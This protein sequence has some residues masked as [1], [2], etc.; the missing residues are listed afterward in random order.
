MRWYLFALCALSLPASAARA[1]EPVRAP[2]STPGSP[3]ELD[4]LL[5]Y[6]KFDEAKGTTAADAS[7]N[8]L[9]ATLRGGHWST[10][11]NGAALQ[12]E[13]NGE[14]LDY[15]NSPALNFKAS[16][17]FTFAGWVKSK[18][19]RGAIV[20]QRNSRDAGAA[21]DITLEDGKLGALVRS[22][23]KENGEHAFVTGG[24]INDGDWHHFALT[25][26]S[27]TNIELFIDGAS[28]GKATGADAGGPITTNLR[29]LGSERLWV[30]KKIPNAQFI[31]AI[32][33]FCVFDRAL[34]AK[35]IRQLAGQVRK[36]AKNT[37]SEDNPRKGKPG[38]ID[39]KERTIEFSGVKVTAMLPSDA[40]P[41]ENTV[42]SKYGV[43]LENPRVAVSLT[44]DTFDKDDPYPIDDPDAKFHRKR[45]EQNQKNLGMK[46]EY[47]K[48]VKVS[49][50]NGIE[51]LTMPQTTKEGIKLDNG[52][53][54]RSFYLKRTAVWASV[55]FLGDKVP[56]EIVRKVFDSMKIEFV[57]P[58]REDPTKIVEGTK[59]IPTT[60]EKK[61]TFRTPARA[62][63]HLTSSGV[64]WWYPDDNEVFD[65][66]VIEG[67]FEQSLT[68]D[69][70]LQ[71]LKDSKKVSTNATLLKKA[72]CGK[73]LGILFA[74]GKTD[75]VFSHR[76]AAVIDPGAVVFMRVVQSNNDRFTRDQVKQFLNSLEIDTAA[77]AIEVWEEMLPAQIKEYKIKEAGVSVWLDRAP[78]V[79]AEKKRV[80]AY[81]PDSAN[82]K[83]EESRYYLI[84]E[85]VTTT[86]A[87]EF[88]LRKKEIGD[89][90]FK[91]DGPRDSRRLRMTYSGGRHGI[92]WDGQDRNRQFY[93][94]ILGDKQLRMSAKFAS[95]KDPFFKLT[96]LTDDRAK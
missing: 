51:S 33:E 38:N 47:V 83:P 58:L 79:K 72:D 49:G 93:F 1:D 13:K 57:G 91:E 40:S 88:E 84:V 86:L 44:I 21:I 26:D 30:Q 7:R 24:L 27:G 74:E 12:F 14:Y 65:V 71:F 20:S 81:W 22:D 11:V 69:G 53:A 9:K 6:W 25:R 56:E 39:W 34:S 15:G 42:S 59:G 8:K 66:Q 50:F 77:P 48:T 28:E 19:Q 89:K 90:L 52:T 60:I 17:A 75:D 82:T 23:Y 61:V 29:T 31:G 62:Q 18:S 10:G 64:H 87:K 46:Y 92:I 85:P 94:T 37:E 95:E 54:N 32:D 80:I 78:K 3:A 73:Q 16:T 2:K 45:I 43:V 96:K 70:L 63:K 41:R 5:A 67:Y 68:H 55:D 4:G 35:E 76:R 36:L